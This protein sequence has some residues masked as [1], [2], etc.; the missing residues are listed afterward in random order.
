MRRIGSRGKV[1]LSIQ[2]YKEKCERSIAD[3]EAQLANIEDNKSKTFLI[4]SK[5]KHSYESRLKLRMTKQANYEKLVQYDQVIEMVT[6]EA[7]AG[8]LPESAKQSL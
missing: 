2:L 1:E 5:R 6:R 3:L 4:L 8:T 7:L